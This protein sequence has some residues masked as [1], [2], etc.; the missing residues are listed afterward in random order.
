[1][2]DFL[3]ELLRKINPEEQRSVRVFF[4]SLRSQINQTRLD[5]EL[6]IT[7]QWREI[8]HHLK[9]DQ[10]PPP[11][12]VE[13]WYETQEK[14]GELDRLYNFVE[15]KQR[16]AVQEPDL[17]NQEILDYVRQI[18]AEFTELEDKTPPQP[19]SLAKKSPSLGNLFGFGTSSSDPFSQIR[20][21]FSDEKI[22]KALD[23]TL[24]VINKQMKAYYALLR[25]LEMKGSEYSRL[26]SE[27]LGSMVE[28]EAF[29]REGE[30]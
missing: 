19:L 25:H 6:E 9:Q 2:S 12:S 18:N 20:E 14:M 30:D 10:L 8:E 24:R 3:G 15:G 27:K 26:L 23:G 7:Q 11:A 22:Q 21:L 5:L 13:D 1:M 29:T 16:S 28:D 4:Q 17:D